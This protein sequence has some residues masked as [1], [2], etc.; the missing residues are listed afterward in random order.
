MELTT[1][2]ILNVWQ[3]GAAE[4]AEAARLF[5]YFEGEQ[6]ILDDDSERYDGAE[7]NLIVTNWI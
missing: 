5:E 2:Q 1:E 7:R 3:L 4:R 6:S